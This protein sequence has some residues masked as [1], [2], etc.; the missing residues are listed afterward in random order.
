MFGGLKFFIYICGMAIVYQ[1]RRLD[2]NEIFY[3]GIGKSKRRLKSKFS[4]NTLWWN[5]VNKHN[6]YVEILYQDISW[7]EA[8]TIETE[9]IKKYGRIDLKTGILC[10]MTDGGDGLNNIT[11]ELRSKIGLKKGFKH[12]EETK[13][14]ISNSIKNENHYRYNTKVSKDIRDKISNTLKGKYV[15][16][17]NVT[18][19]LKDED[20]IWIKENYKPYHPT[21]N[22]ISISKKFNVSA[23]TIRQIIY[24]ITWKHI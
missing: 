16:E 7:E 20:V 8:C 4:R 2:T 12:T 10:N 23:S 22:G 5:I 1:H 19:K 13:L 21:L 24:S 3:I 6:Y 14:K 9:L 17:K 11:D 15:G 18:S